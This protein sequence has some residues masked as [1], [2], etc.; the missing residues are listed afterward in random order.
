MK[1]VLALLGLTLLLSSCAPAPITSVPPDVDTGVNPET[2]ALVPAGEFLSG[3]F[4]HEA[5]LAYDYEIMVTDVTNRQFADYLNEA[6]AAGQIKIQD[7]FVVGFYPGDEFRGYRHEEEIAAGDWLHLPLEDA[8]LRIIWQDDL[9][10]VIEGY[11]NHPVVMVSW[12]GAQAYCE[13]Y[14]GRLPTS[15]EWEKA[16]RGID[17]RAYPW[18]NEIQ[19]ENANYYGSHDPFEEN[20]GKSGDTTPVGFYSGITFRNYTT[21]DSPSPYGL[22]DMAGNVEQWMGDVYAN[23]HYRYLRGGSKLSYGFDLRVWSSNNVRPDY[24]SPSI[25]FRCARDPLEP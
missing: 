8:S 17:G 22:Y 7:N 14:G 19:G 9:F 13:Y 6:L 18:G 23:Q 5:E 16:A 12:F 3:Q 24:Y 25:G 2:W 4:N 15:L 10:S 20:Y 11:E 1:S 21:L